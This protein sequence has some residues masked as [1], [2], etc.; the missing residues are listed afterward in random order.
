MVFSDI[1]RAR[2]DLT[3]RCRDTDLLPKVPG[4][5]A[6]HD[7]VQLMHNGVRVVEGGY[8][9]SWMTEVIRQLHGHHEPQ[10]ELAFHA[11]VERVA[12]TS[13]PSPSIMELGAYWAYY[14]LWFLHRNPSGKAY[15]V[16]PDPGFLD[17]GRRNFD[18]NGV[19]GTFHQAAVGREKTI[20]MPFECE[21][22]GQTRDI[23]TEGLASLFERFHLDRLD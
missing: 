6:V 7:G 14:S 8:Y 9:G 19:E 18:V 12:A 21:S 15:L 2:I 22:D 11:V 3:L 10:E 4:A 13:G 1:E 20:P 23:P 16:E 5:G 17:V